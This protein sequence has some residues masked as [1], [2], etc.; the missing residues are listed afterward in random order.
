LRKKRTSQ[1][2]TPRKPKRE[3]ARA[4]KKARR[5]R[6]WTPKN[7]NAASRLL[8]CRLKSKNTV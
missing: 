5:R 1:R 7:W 6:R 8:G 2:K 4:A 3:R